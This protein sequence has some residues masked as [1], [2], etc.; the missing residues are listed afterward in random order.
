MRR[1]VGVGVGWR[2]WKGWGRI[3]DTFC[4]SK[5]SEHFP[6]AVQHT[7]LMCVPCVLHKNYHLKVLVHTHNIATVVHKAR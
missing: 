2:G 7:L 1:R 5:Q 3:E 6:H 4:T